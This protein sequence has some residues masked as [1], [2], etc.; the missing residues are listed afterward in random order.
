MGR[1]LQKRRYDLIRIEVKSNGYLDKSEKE[2][3]KLL[4]E[5]GVF[6]KILIAKKGDKRGSI[7]YLDYGQKY[8]KN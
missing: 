7:E 8:M 6:S 4:L 5:K 1:Y 3:C 2:K